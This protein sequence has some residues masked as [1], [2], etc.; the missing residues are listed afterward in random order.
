MFTINLGLFATQFPFWM[1]KHWTQWTHTYL[2][3][4]QWDS[5]PVKNQ[6][7]RL[8]SLVASAQVFTTCHSILWKLGTPIAFTSN[9]SPKL[10][11]TFSQDRT[12]L[13][14]FF[15][16]LSVKVAPILSDQIGLYGCCNGWQC[17]AEGT[18]A[19]ST[20]LGI[21]NSFQK[22][23]CHFCKLSLSLLAS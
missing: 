10:G 9:F 6:P 5:P 22:S 23:V 19:V 17:G 18:N 21:T 7:R 11:W 14:F 3:A 20:T 1:A 4:S 12:P 8:P 15:L 16:F 13:K 2:S